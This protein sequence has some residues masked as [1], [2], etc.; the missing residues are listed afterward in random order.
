M[1]FWK[2]V[3]VTVSCLLGMRGLVLFATELATIREERKSD[4]P[5]KELCDKGEASTSPKMRAA[6]LHLTSERAAPVLIAAVL[7][8]TSTMANDICDVVTSPMRSS[9]VQ[10]GCVVFMAVPWL[11]PLLRFFGILSPSRQQ[12]KAYCRTGFGDSIILL[13]APSAD[14]IDDDDE[15]SEAQQSYIIDRKRLLPQRRRNASL[16]ADIEELA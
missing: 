8:A 10:M 14:N 16:K 11:A 12:P 3:L 7:R 2:I 15:L 4:E 5:L 9:L 1:N 6:C 13:N